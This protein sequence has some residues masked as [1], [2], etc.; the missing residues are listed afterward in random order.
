MPT[1]N[2]I[3][4]WGEKL[5]Y[6]NGSIPAS[7]NVKV[8]ANFLNTHHAIGQLQLGFREGSEPDCIIILPFP[9]RHCCYNAL[10][11]TEARSL[12]D[13]PGHLIIRIC[14]ENVVTTR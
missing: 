8:K 3:E 14:A 7:Q 2:G 13:A 10:G 5:Q 4:P 11:A 1:P 9:L 6:P 12:R